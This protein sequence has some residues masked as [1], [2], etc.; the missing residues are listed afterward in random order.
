MDTLV[1]LAGQFPLLGSARDLHPLADIHASRTK[2]KERQPNNGCLF[3]YVLVKVLLI[4]N[5]YLIAFA[6]ST[7]RSH[8]DVGIVV[9]IISGNHSTFFT[10]CA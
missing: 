2:D 5:L 8:H 4:E 10:S 9:G 1:S 3:L 7:P 6:Q